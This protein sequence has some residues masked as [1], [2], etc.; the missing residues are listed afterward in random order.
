MARAIGHRVLKAGSSG[1]VLALWNAFSVI[2]QVAI[3]SMLDADLVQ[4]L[5]G[6]LRDELVISGFRC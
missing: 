2:V 6:C 3:C 4:W 1:R 5:E